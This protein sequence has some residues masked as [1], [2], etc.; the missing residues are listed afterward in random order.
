MP[1]ATAAY[2]S[3]SSDRQPSHSCHTLRFS[4]SKIYNEAKDVCVWSRPPKVALKVC[5]AFVS[6]A[7]YALVSR[8]LA[9]AS[10]LDP[11]RARPYAH[12]SVWVGPNKKQGS[13]AMCCCVL[14]DRV[15]NS[16][17]SF[18]SPVSAFSCNKPERLSCYAKLYHPDS[19]AASPPRRV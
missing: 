7:K 17:C 13:R 4:I 16:P 11:K 15:L 8:V 5:M 18:S 6:F 19:M 9:D 12:L 14:R 3:C 2:K 1:H 10:N